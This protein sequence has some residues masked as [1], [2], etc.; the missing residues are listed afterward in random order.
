MNLAPIAFALLTFAPAPQPRPYSL[1]ADWPGWRGP[2]RTGVSPAR[3]LLSSWP[4]EGPRLLWAADDLGEGYSAP[5][6]VGDRLYVM[7]ADQAAEHLRAYSV[8]DGKLLWSVNV[9][10]VGEVKGPRY[11]GPRATPT[12]DGRRL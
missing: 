10:K 5:S 6:V 11:P 1:S 7:G 2:E 9:G 8:K 12:V 3:G 4:S